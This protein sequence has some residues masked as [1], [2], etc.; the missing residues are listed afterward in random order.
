MSKLGS[1][2]I[3]SGWYPIGVSSDFPSREKPVAVS[4]WGRKLAVY[5]DSQGK[6]VAVS[7]VCPHG[8]ASLLIGDVEGSN[9]I[10]PYHRWTF[11]AGVCTMVPAQPDG[12]VPVNALLENYPV[13]ED[14]N[15]GLV[16]VYVGT[17]LA[18]DNKPPAAPFFADKQF[19]CVAGQ[20]LWQVPLPLVAENLMDVA[21]VHATHAFGDRLYSRVE[22]YDVV[23]GAWGGSAQVEYKLSETGALFMP[24]DRATRAGLTPIEVTMFFPGAILVRFQSGQYQLAVFTA[25]TP[26][27][28]STTRLRYFFFRNYF[29]KGPE[30]YLKVVDFLA[31]LNIARILKEDQ[32]VVETIETEGQLPR[33]VLRSDAFPAFYRELWRKNGLAEAEL[34]YSVTASGKQPL[35]SPMRGQIRTYERF[36]RRSFA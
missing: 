14:A 28:D 35:P 6:L 12:K 27:T 3:V 33:I 34:G 21:H 1:E 2:T 36:C 26:E 15:S 16:W 22:P 9:L 11:E 7:S 20:T 32:R 17:T 29:N 5:R 4:L 25:L 30:P 13:H 24:G 31:T 18:D 19:R 10:C 8:G 23:R